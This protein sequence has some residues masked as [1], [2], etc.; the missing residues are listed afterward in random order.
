V[1]PSQWHSN[2]ANGGTRP[3]AQ[4]LGTH[5][6]N[7]CSHLKTHFKQKFRTKYAE[8]CVF[9]GK[10]C[11]KSSQRLRPQTPVCLRPMGDPPPDSHVVT[12]AYHYNFVKFISSTKVGLLPSKKNK[13]CIFQILQL[14]FTSNSVVFV[15]RWRKNISCSRAQGTLATPLPL[16]G[17]SNMETWY[18]YSK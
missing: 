12:P 9:F 8:K 2:G 15:D 17:F 13:F 18:K 16:P 7:F 3:G 14:F 4:A 6:H 11:K 5:K 10:R 1:P